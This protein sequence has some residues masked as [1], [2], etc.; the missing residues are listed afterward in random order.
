MFTIESKRKCQEFLKAGAH[1]LLEGKEQ[2]VL[3]ILEHTV[4]LLIKLNV[5]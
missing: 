4:A 2:K 5:T 1:G 3:K